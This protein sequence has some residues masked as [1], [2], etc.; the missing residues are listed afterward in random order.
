MT[1]EVH[2]YIV[3]DLEVTSTPS[4]SPDREFDQ[5]CYLAGAA[6]VSNGKVQEQWMNETYTDPLGEFINWVA[7]TTEK[8][9]ENL[10]K[11][12]EPDP[13]KCFTKEQKE[14]WMRAKLCVYCNKEISKS[15]IAEGNYKVLAHN[16]YTQQPQGNHYSHKD[17][18]EAIRSLLEDPTAGAEGDTG[19]AHN[20]C[21]LPDQAQKNLNVY[22]FNADFDLS[23]LLERLAE[24]PHLFG[25]REVAA[26]PKNESG[27][28]FEFS[29]KHQDAHEII[30]TKEK[31]RRDGNRTFIYPH[32]KSARI[33]KGISFKE[34]WA[35][36][37]TLRIA[38]PDGPL[39]F[40][41]A[42]K[43]LHRASLS[44]YCQLMATVADDPEILKQETTYTRRV[45]GSINFKD[46]LALFGQ[47]SLD[48]VVSSRM[49]ISKKKF[50][51]T[52]D[53]HAALRDRVK[54]VRVAIP[55]TSA[56]Y[57]SDDEF[58]SFCLK[59]WFPHQHID[60][61][62]R[63][64]DDCLPAID[65]LGSYSVL[66][67]S[68]P[69]REVYDRMTHV[70][71]TYCGG[72]TPNA[73]DRFARK[74][75][76]TDVLLTCDILQNLINLIQRGTGLHPCNALTGPSLA[77]QNALVFMK[78]AGLH[79][80][81]FT[82]PAMVKFVISMLYGGLVFKSVNHVKANVP[83]IPG[84]D[85]KLDTVEVLYDDVCSLY[86]F[87]QMKRLAC[88]D[89]RWG[90][91]EVSKHMVSKHYE[92]CKAWTGRWIDLNDQFKRSAFVEFSGDYIC[93]TCFLEKGKT[94]CQAKH[95]CVM[96]QDLVTDS[97]VDRYNIFPTKYKVTEDM[98]SKVDLECFRRTGKEPGTSEKLMM[99]LYQKFA[100]KPKY[101]T[102]SQQ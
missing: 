84:Y 66:S 22:F 45:H 70:M 80:E 100:T 30:T 42:A 34:L 65:A 50:K 96:C 58:L 28:F 86:G 40:D 41:I 47:V 13:L 93:D 18:L 72:G 62:K 95:G 2:T 78:R 5:K 6:V 85:P 51:S 3:A 90:D 68:Y 20:L 49:P 88:S 44:E 29:L 64:E 21:N 39:L 71:N 76:A 4:T 37:A 83:G 91:S 81:L 15:D 53:W 52:A 23:F 24:N 56:M 77:W 32:T 73:L 36:R 38:E 97:G 17:Q 7:R 11:V 59:G 16:H 67:K 102:L 79:V 101:A 82:D 98:M 94:E 25:A 69:S 12:G 74:Y 92:M 14:T 19:C 57:E 27:K 63:L 10:A 99:D 35:E 75:C 61:V 33:L 87:A 55:L 43:H 89:Y 46:A 8:L 54:E 9:F 60:T 1:G 31:L 48:S 26:L